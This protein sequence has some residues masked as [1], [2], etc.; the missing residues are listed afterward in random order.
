[1]TANFGAWELAKAME[2]RETKDRE[3]L[4]VSICTAIGSPI[5]TVYSRIKY[6]RLMA[7]SISGYKLANVERTQRVFTDIGIFN[8]KTKRLRVTC[9]QT[10]KK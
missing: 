10:E 2:Y 8:N 4:C 7:S 1:M 9:V 3:R 6:I 5:S